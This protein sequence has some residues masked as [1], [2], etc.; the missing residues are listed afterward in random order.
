MFDWFPG[1]KKDSKVV[2]FPTKGSDYITPPA[3][4]KVPKEEHKVFYRLGLTDTNRVAFN[5]GYSEVTMNRAGVQQLIDQL[6]FFM[7]QLQDEGVEDE[8]E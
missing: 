1:K 7:N 2:P 4:P 5:M 6:T 8:S 3:P